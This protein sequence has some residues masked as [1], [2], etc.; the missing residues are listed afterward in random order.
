M[1]WDDSL[2]ASCSRK[3]KKGGWL[4]IKARKEKV[5]E[6][7]RLVENVKSELVRKFIEKSQVILETR[8][9]V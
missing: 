6:E 5:M 8:F 2:C 1:A 9:C 4:D 7:S 3:G